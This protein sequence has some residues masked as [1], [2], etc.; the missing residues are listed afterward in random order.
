MGLRGEACLETQ[1]VLEINAGE[2]VF[3]TVE[4]KYSNPA[5]L[6]RAQNKLGTM[7]LQSSITARKPR[8][9]LTHSHVG[10]SDAIAY[11]KH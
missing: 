1:T 2:A 4:Y 8:E 10:N 7:K 3:L 9:L 11:L 5:L 6:Q